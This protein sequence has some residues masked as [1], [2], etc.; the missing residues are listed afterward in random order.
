MKHFLP[1][2][3]V[4]VALSSGCTVP[5]LNIEI[6]G[7]PDLPGW[8]GPQVVQYEHDILIIEGL[9][10]IPAEIDA[11][12]TTK[13]IAHV[14]NIGDRILDDNDG[15][16]E[17]EL[18]DYCQGLFKIERVKCSTGTASADQTSCNFKEILKDETVRIEWTLEQYD[19]KPVQLKTICPPDG[20]KV[21]VKYAYTTSSLTTVSFISEAELERTIE[22]RAIKSTDSYIVVGQ[23]P[24]KPYI[25]VED[26]QPIP[27]YDG[28]RT[29]L[30]LKIKN[31]GTGDLNNE[32]DDGTGNKLI[33][34]EGKDITVSGIEQNGDL[35]PISGECEFA[36]STWDKQVR[37]I[38]KESANYICK[39]DLSK[40]DGKVTKTATRHVEA[41]V[42]YKYIFTK[43]VQVVVNPKIVG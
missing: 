20:V 34:L 31:L 36:S 39:V 1:L 13:I 11:G 4:L 32:H 41:T 25:T 27:V 19:T 5:F 33:Y 16:I 3:L 14:K 22:E 26:K 42:K 21:S 28:A 38:G 43:A 29:I 15:P 2:A 35:S 24:I 7:L 23:G 30:Q 10:A 37:L 8:G 9:Q 40:L 18:Y 17:I 12:Q 6:P